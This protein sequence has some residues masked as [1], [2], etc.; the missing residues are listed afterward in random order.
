MAPDESPAEPWSDIVANRIDGAPESGLTGVRLAAGDEL[1]PIWTDAQLYNR[2][3]TG[4]VA[5]DGNGDGRDELY[6]AVQDLHKPPSDSG[7]D[8]P[9][10]DDVPAASIVCSTDYGRTWTP[11]SAPMFTGH[12]FTTVFFLDFGRSNAGARV[13]GEDA[14]GYVYAYG[15]DNNW[16]DSFS[17]RVP[18]PQDLYLA[19]VPVGA[20][21]DRGRWEFF[22]GLADREPGWTSDIDSRR[23]VLHEERRVY[24]GAVTPDGMSV[25]A[26]GGVVYN[27]GLRR[28]L[29][30]S[31][32]EFTWEFY[33]APYPWGPWNL[34]LHKD[35]GPYPWWGA[36]PGTPGPKNGGYATTIPSKF[37]SEDG[38]RM[39]V[40]SNWFVGVG[41]PEPNYHFSLRRLLLTPHGGVVRAG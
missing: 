26:Q 32:T 30:T 24:P 28:Y 25:L 16:R 41:H 1:G 10:F 13:L 18:D 37:I 5:V 38:R 6:L 4:I 23:P 39:W 33:E 22:T 19:R 15:L 11:T 31:W 35:F 36:A 2:K 12:V 3:P 9:G 7:T 34:F 14:A 40:Q 29:Y 17:D 21:Q 27:P 8:E 20:I